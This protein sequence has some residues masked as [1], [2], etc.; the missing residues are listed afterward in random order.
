MKYRGCPVEEGTRQQ[1]HSG[2][3][4]AR[5]NTEIVSNIEDARTIDREEV[6][7]DP[8]DHGDTHSVDGNN[9]LE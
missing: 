2:E 9:G 7:L 1:D 6:K 8:T 3:G 5:R 4:L